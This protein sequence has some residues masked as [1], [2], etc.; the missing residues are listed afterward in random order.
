MLG[1][2]FLYIIKMMEKQA[3]SGLR[4]LPRE[5]LIKHVRIGHLGAELG[6][7]GI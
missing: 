5:I 4:Q 7:S 2:L 1:T 6:K 3:Q